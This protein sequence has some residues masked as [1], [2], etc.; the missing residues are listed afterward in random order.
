MLIGQEYSIKSDRLNIT[1]YQRNWGSKRE[2]TAVGNYTTLRE[3]LTALVNLE[4]QLTEL[5]D[6]ATVV[7]KQ[8]ELYELIKEV[9]DRRV[10]QTAG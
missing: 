3:A 5:V 6:L 4:V 1:L 9:R 8:D 10:E 2:W 7:K